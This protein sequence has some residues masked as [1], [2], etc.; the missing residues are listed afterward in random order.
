MLASIAMVV[1]SKHVEHADR[2]RVDDQIANQTPRL[3]DRHVLLGYTD[4]DATRV[5]SFWF[6]KTLQKD[7]QVV[8]PLWSRLLSY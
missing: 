5:C 4:H 8:L 3:F 1:A 7:F 2:S 6:A